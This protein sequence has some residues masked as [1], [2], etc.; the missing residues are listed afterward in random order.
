[1]VTRQEDWTALI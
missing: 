1:M